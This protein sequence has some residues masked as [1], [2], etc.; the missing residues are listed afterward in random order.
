MSDQLRERE[1]AYR[2]GQREDRGKEEKRRR[3]EGKKERTE[4]K[5]REEK[6]KM[7]RYVRSLWYEYDRHTLV[8]TTPYPMMQRVSS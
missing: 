3:R 4:Q 5:R 7:K 1:A 8:L 6:G 2:S